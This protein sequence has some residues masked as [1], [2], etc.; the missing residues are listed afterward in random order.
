MGSAVGTEPILTGGPI[1][2]RLLLPVLTLLLLAYTTAPSAPEDSSAEAAQA[3]LGSLDETQ[4]E[5]A[6]FE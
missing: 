5:Q 6:A 4:L 1:S 3:S 2:P